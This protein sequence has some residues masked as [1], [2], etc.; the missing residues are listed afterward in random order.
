MC[1]SVQRKFWPMHESLFATQNRWEKMTNPTPLFDSLATAAGVDMTPYRTCTTK[2]LTVP[3]IEAD[4]DRARSVGVQATPTFFVGGES[5]AG[6]EHDLR[7]PIEAALAKGRG[8][9]KPAN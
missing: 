6:A 2:H 7:K 4:R 1:A 8:A 5:F 3:L 9:K